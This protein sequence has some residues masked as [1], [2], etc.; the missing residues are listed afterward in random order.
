MGTHP[1]FESDFD[2]LTDMDRATKRKMKSQQRKKKANLLA[3]EEVPVSKPEKK[4]EDFEERETEEADIKSDEPL[5]KKA[6]IGQNDESDSGN[7]EIGG[8]EEADIEIGQNDANNEPA[9]EFTKDTK[10]NLA[11]R[12]IDLNSD[13]ETAWSSLSEKVSEET[14]KAIVEGMG[15][16]NMMPIQARAI[17]HLLTG[18]DVLAAART[19]SGKTLAFLVPIV[20]LITKLKFLDRNGTGAIILS[21]TRELAMQTYGV[22]KELMEDHPQTH[23][24]IMGGSDRK[25]E[26]KRLGNGVNIVVATPGRLLD[27]L[28][29]TASFMVKNLMCLCIDEADRI[30][31]VGF[32]EE[33]KQIIKRIPKKRQTMMFS[34]TQTRKTEDLARIS[35]KGEPLYVGVDDKQAEATSSALEQGFVVSPADK[36]LRVLYTF[37]KKNKNKKIMV[38]FS[39]CMSVKYHYELFNYIDV[40]CLSIHG[41]QKQTKRTS[42]FF[43]FCNADTGI[44]FCTDVAARGLDIPEVDWIVQYDPP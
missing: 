2:C 18:K 32:E 43:S 40:T 26:A 21:P 37:L 11:V 9:E 33:M 7:E 44:L 31:E 28:Q 29:N 17:P 14:I 10:G 6:K 19:G 25:A 5:N 34:A 13:V 3:S 39:S 30:L 1:I 16:Q 8:N 27:H 12:S 36:R 41:K 22:L 20:E 15:Y 24:L 38:F 42:T 35:L 4:P 23:G